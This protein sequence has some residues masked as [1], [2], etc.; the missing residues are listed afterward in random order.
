MSDKD[1][2][3]SGN[4]F[5][6]ITGGADKPKKDNSSL[7]SKNEDKIEYVFKDVDEFIS[8]I[9]IIFEDCG[10]NTQVIGYSLCF[11]AHGEEGIYPV[12]S[13]ASHPNFENDMIGIAHRHLNLI[14]MQANSGVLNVD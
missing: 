6:L 3:N 13:N 1:D 2:F 9:K 8:H 5:K 11:I 4:V 10:K 14:T 7:S 12:F